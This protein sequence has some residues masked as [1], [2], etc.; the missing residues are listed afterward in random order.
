MTIDQS[1]TRV[2]VVVDGYLSAHGPE[3]FV[4]TRCHKFQRQEL[5]AKHAFTIDASQS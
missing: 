5:D 4:T 2:V 3:D 1:K